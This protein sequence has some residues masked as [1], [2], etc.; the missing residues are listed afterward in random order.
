MSAEDVRGTL[1]IAFEEVLRI[2]GNLDGLKID[3][4]FALGEALGI[5]AKAKALVARDVDD[6]KQR[7]EE[8]RRME[9]ENGM[10]EPQFM[11]GKPFHD[12]TALETLMGGEREAME[13]L[14]HDTAAFGRIALLIDDRFAAIEA[15]LKALE[16][17]NEAVPGGAGVGGVVSATPRQADEQQLPQDRD[18]AGSAVE[19]GGQVPLPAGG[20]TAP[21][22]DDG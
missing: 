19:T 8:A 9:G 5:L 20:G 10:R 2:S 3:T 7:Y 14:A 6:A 22:R 12:R 17:R 4:V 1:Q 18:A 15:R 16:A 11:K 13:R 21:A